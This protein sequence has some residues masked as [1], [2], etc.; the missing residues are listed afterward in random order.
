VRTKKGPNFWLRPW[1]I[2]RELSTTRVAI[3]V[4]RSWPL[5]T[6]RSNWPTC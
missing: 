6:M 2:C 5:V 3:A 4:V 1:V